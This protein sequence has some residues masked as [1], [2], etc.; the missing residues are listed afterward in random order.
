MQFRGRWQLQIFTN[1]HEILYCTYRSR[2]FFVSRFDATL[3]FKL[4]SLVLAPPV[5][6]QNLCGSAMFFAR[7][8]Y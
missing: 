8:R 1:T 6:I 4:F 7:Y 2:P 3:P 5:G